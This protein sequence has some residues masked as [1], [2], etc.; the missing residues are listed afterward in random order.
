[1]ALF[2]TADLHLSLGA[3][4][5]MDIFSG[6]QNYLQKIENNWRALIKEE[7][8]VVIAGDISWAMKLT[9]TAEDFAF[10]H[11]LPGKKII[12]KGNH[13]YWWETRRKMEGFIEQSGF[14]SLSILFNNCFA[15]GDYAIC[16]SRG[17]SYDCPQS[18]QLVL[19]RE[20]GRLQTSLEA[21]KAE[22]LTPIVF[23]HYPP[24]YG[25][26]RCDE[27]MEV[28]H[29]FDVPRCY[30]GHLHGHSH[31]RAVIGCYEGIEMRLIAADFCSF[32]PVLVER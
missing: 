5:P 27:I 9:S 6:W 17:W 28:L 3:D 26:Y 13:D 29:R 2:A 4:K 18:E 25:D 19:L 16:G 10:L 22:G 32:A 7:D 21:A 14:S 31:Q 20:C 24:V 12:L 1:M 8:T 23:L 15:Y 30:Y 11:S